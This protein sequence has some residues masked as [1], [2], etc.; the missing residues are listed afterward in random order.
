MVCR[1]FKSLIQQL[2]AAK[3]NPQVAQELLQSGVTAHSSAAV[4]K[5]TPSQLPLA[6]EGQNNKGDVCSFL[7]QVR[8]ILI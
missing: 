4:G 6:I 8:G 1:V 7:Q 3:D 5:L 2:R